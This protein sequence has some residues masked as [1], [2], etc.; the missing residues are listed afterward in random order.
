VSLLSVS[1]G[2]GWVGWC[3]S[4]LMVLPSGTSR[5]SR[6][7]RGASRGLAWPG[8]RAR[9]RVRRCVGS[10]VRRA[11][12]GCCAQSRRTHAGGGRAAGCSRRSG[13]RVRRR[14]LTPGSWP[15]ASSVWSQGPARF[16]ANPRYGARYPPYLVGDLAARV[17]TRCRGELGVCV[18]ARAW[19]CPTVN[20][21]PDLPNGARH[22]LRGQEPGC[23]CPRDGTCACCDV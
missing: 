2:T 6:Q 19:L 14:S 12:T 23:S 9:R 5:G 17:A 22:R 8:G 10:C 4:G 13:S 1:R 11:R 3:R 7:V 15:A 16:P 21:R 18:A 20:G